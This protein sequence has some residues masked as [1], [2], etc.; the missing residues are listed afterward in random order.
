[1]VHFLLCSQ[2]RKIIKPIY[3][4]GSLRNSSTTLKTNNKKFV[5][6]FVLKTMTKTTTVSQVICMKITHKLGN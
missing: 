6:H 4:Q 3:I 2:L 5:L 1:M